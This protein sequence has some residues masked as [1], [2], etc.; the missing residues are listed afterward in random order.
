M[1]RAPGRNVERAMHGPTEEELTV[2]EA[3]VE[4]ARAAYEAA[5]RNLEKATLTPP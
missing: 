5:C 4:Q 2:A 3:A 1:W